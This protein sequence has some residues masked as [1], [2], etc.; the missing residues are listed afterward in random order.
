MEEDPV[1]AIEK[2]LE[3]MAEIGDFEGLAVSQLT[4]LQRDY[5]ATLAAN[6]VEEEEAPEPGYE[7]CDSGSEEEQQDWGELQSAEVEPPKEQKSATSQQLSGDQVKRI[8][9]A[10]QSLALPTPAWAI[11]LSDETFLQLISDKLR[12]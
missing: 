6:I 12:P 3:G 10:M 4:Q 7:V 1:E 9:E 8:K 5:E 11:N 2:A